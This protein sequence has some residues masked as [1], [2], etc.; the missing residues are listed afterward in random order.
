[1]ASQ[2]QPSVTYAALVAGPSIDSKTITL[3]LQVA[4]SQGYYTVG[5]VAAGL[6]A[7]ASAQGISANA[8]FLEARFSSEAPVLNSGLSLPT[9]ADYTYKYIPT[10]D[11]IQILVNGVE[12]TPSEP[13][14]PG[15]LNDTI[16]LAAV[17]NRL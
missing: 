2:N 17:W 14:P 6:K 11:N 1:M 13:I 3:W 15:V 8:Q 9:Q 4:F 10:T 12:F 5:G 16:V 7:Y